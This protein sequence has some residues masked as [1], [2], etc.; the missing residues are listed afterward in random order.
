MRKKAQIAH[1]QN[2]VEALNSSCEQ[3]IHSLEKERKCSQVTMETA[4]LIADI[5]LTQIRFKEMNGNMFLDV[6]SKETKKLEMLKG[7]AVNIDADN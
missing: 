4:L 5:M 7:I 6:F 3:M 1:L 2:Q